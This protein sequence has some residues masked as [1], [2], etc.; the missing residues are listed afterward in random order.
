MSDML[1]KE[2]RWSVFAVI[3]AFAPVVASEPEVELGIEWRGFAEPGFYGQDQS[4]FSARGELG[5]D[6]AMLSG[7][8][9]LLLFGR[10]DVHDDERTHLDLR[11]ASWVY[12]G[13]EWS[14]KGGVSK[15]FWGVTESLHLVD[16][17][18]QTDGVEAVDD[19]DKLGQPMLKLASEKEW[20]TISLFW[21]PYFRERSYPSLD[22]RL[23][24][25]FEVR[26][27][28]A[29]FESGA[30][31]KHQDVALRY[32]HYIDE[33]E[34]ALAH[35]SGTARDPLLVFNNNPLDPAF[36]PFYQQIDQTSLEAQYIYDS[37]LLKLE[38][39][40]NKGLGDRYAAAVAGFEY[41]Q[42]GI[43][44][45]YADLGWIIEYLFDERKNDV[46]VIFEDD[47]FIGWRY[48]FNDADSSEILFG[49]IFDT[50]TDERI[51]SLEASQ[52]ISSDLKVFV[53]AWMFEGLPRLTPTSGLDSDKKTQFLQTEDFIQL[54]LV[55]YF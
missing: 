19:E 9:E 14:L 54:E 34:F 26:A 32:A 18:N 10:Y 1:G 3:F 42:V 25:P 22:G 41:T 29:Q 2:L 39:L 50:H 44:E 31:N 37:W 28:E 45:S 40:T 38:A 43:F 33:L 36:I 5:Y 6:G 47:V 24:L 16:I 23:A 35:F 27:D 12:V 46:S 30:E 55:K 15:E 11:E 7:D 52:R 13:D 8:Y 20:G 53:E 4:R 49:G 48:A 21:L 17:I 51:Y